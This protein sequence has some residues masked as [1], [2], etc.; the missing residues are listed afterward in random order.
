MSGAPA[1]GQAQQPCSCAQKHVGALVP[2]AP[3]QQLQS[4]GLRRIH[5]AHGPRPPTRY[6]PAGRAAGASLPAADRHRVPVRPR[7]RGL[8]KA[9]VKHAKATASIHAVQGK[10][11]PCTASASVFLAVPR[12]GIAALAARAAPLTRCDSTRARGLAIGQSETA[13][14]PIT[15]LPPSPR[16]RHNAPVPLAPQP[17]SRRGAPSSAAPSPLRSPPGRVRPAATTA[18]RSG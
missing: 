11:P 4:G 7:K 17:F 6:R 1:G 10:L 3:A 8:P 16:A 13:G 9:E 12:Q 2:A 15:A 18:R 5:N 14:P